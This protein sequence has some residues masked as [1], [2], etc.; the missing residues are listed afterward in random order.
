MKEIVIQELTPDKLKETVDVATRA[1]DS[2]TARGNA[3]IDFPLSL[4]ECPRVH[5][6]LIALMNDKVVG[7]VQCMHSN[8]SV[9]IYNILWV[10]VDPP[11]QKQGIG[12]H[13]VDKASAYI[14]QEFLE[15]K[16]GTIVLVSDVDPSYY[17]KSG[18]E[19]ANDTHVGGTI[20]RKIV[21]KK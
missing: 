15:N 4:N 17:E 16:L 19:T 11:H 9:D 7:A 1:F 18:F 10:C 5:K 12:R 2:D 8:L 14:E 6:T 20:M 3:E 13:I 21:G